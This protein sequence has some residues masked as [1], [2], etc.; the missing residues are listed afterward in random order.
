MVIPSIL[1]ALIILVGAVIIDMI[2]GE[3]KEYVHPVA[4]VGKFSTRAEKAFMKA[5]NKVLAGFAFLVVI[6]LIF[7]L[8]AYIVLRIISP[9][10]FL[11]FIVAMILF[12][13][14]FSITSMGNHVKPIIK[15]LETDDLETA[16]T[17]LSLI[18]RRDTSS[19]DATHIC[20]ATIETV[21]E[22]FVDGF[23]TPMMFFALFGII[24]ALV[25][26]IINTM[27]SMIGYRNREYFEFGRWTAIAD[28][29]INY[30]P[31][32]VSA[33]IIAFSSE[34][35]NYRVQSVPL[36]DV[37]V[38]TES[39]NAGWPMGSIATSLNV[40]L[41]KYGQYVLNENGFDPTV[42]DIKRTMNIYY[43]SIYLSFLIFILPIMIIVF[44][45]E[46]I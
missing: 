19:M 14:T 36:K 31:A 6:I 10:Q 17:K 25:A 40:K 9:V 27:D 23:L 35:L 32:R 38:L 37:R 2:F 30:I 29:I 33:A 20:S 18:V 45:L 5:G 41:E 12:K 7:T 21:S 39:T 43:T 13:T 11:Y 28:T 24:G 44:F 16:R 8:P 46:V 42:G 4:L 22:G 34:L 1:A 26:R 15:A 3:P